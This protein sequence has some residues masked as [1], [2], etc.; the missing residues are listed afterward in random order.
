MADFLAE[1]LA[2]I[3]LCWRLERR[4][5]VAL[6]FTTHDRHFMLNGEFV[7]A[8]VKSFDEHRI[9]VLWQTKRN[10]CRPGSSS[11]GG[12]I[13]QAPGQSFTTHFFRFSGV[14]K[15]RSLNHRIGFE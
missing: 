8:F 14:Q 9:K 2:T 15:M 11:H 12:S 10:Q 7:E 3:A 4:D 1:P 13:A 6:G 5:G